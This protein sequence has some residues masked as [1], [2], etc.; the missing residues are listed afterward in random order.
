ML[1]CLFAK[2]LNSRKASL[3]L[4]LAA[5]TSHGR[6]KYTDFLKMATWASIADPVK[7]TATHSVHCPLRP[8][9]VGALLTLCTVCGAG[10]G[11]GPRA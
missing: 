10:G 1:Q 11:G 4:R 9:P 2:V 3:N 8:P 7:G 5:C 6:A